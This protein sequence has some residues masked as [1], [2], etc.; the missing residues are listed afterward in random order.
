MPDSIARTEGICWPTRKFRWVYE[1]HY[2]GFLHLIFSTEIQ[3]FFTHQI[4]T[5]LSFQPTRSNTELS[6]EGY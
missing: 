6:I 2:C 1:K 3:K 5:L 4:I